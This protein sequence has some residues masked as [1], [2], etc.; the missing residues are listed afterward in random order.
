[1]GIKKAVLLYLMTVPVFF[2]IDMVWLGA[3]AKG[4]YRRHL[5]DFLAAK[6]NWPAAMIFYLLFIVGILVFA[7]LPSL[8]KQSLIHCVV[9]GV[10]FGFFTYATYDLTNLATL[11]DWP[12]VIVVVDI[13]WGMVLSGSVATISFLL[14]RRIL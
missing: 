9:M 3:V 12:L 7:V 14:A 11:Q 4:F 10:L 6:F 5:G 2:V 1:M 8:E 13:V